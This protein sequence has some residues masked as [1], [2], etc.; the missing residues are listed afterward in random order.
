M[1]KKLILFFICT[2][3]FFSFHS[4][5]AEVIIN[6][7]QIAGS[8]ANDEFIELYNSGDS[9]ANLT[10]FYIKKKTS[11][12]SESSFVVPSRFEGV[13][14][15]SG[16]YLL[17]AR[18]N[19]Y[20][21]TVS[22]DIFWPSSYSLANNN[23]LT[24]FRGNET[25]KNEVSWQTIEEN[26]SFQ[27]TTT[28]WIIAVA[29]PKAQNPNSSSSA[30][31]GTGTL[32]SNN[33]DNDD[34]HSTQ[35][36]NSTE[37]KNKII[38][39][40]KIKTKIIT[41]NNVFTGT[42]SSFQAA[43]FGYSKEKLNYGKYFWNFGDGDSKEIQTNSTEKL[44]HTYLYPGDYVVTLEYYM[45]FY[46]DVPDASDKM[47]IK[48]TKAN[49]LISAVG[50]SQ[51]FFVELS[52]NTDYDADI[53]N[54]SL[55]SSA[56]NFTFPKNTVISSKKKMTISSV[57]T[58]FS[59]F[60]KDTLKL[61]TPQGRIVFDY[62]ISLIP[63]VPIEK[64]PVQSKQSKISPAVQPLE[65]QLEENTATLTDTQIPVE[66][67]GASIVSSGIVKD[68][69]ISFPS[70]IALIFIGASGGAVYFL[71]KKKIISSAGDDF[72]ILDE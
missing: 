49:F 1:S 39:E 32:I 30:P 58:H 2:I 33:S 71:R 42:A 51:D 12:G 61:I 52:N 55:S 11:S 47:T 9:V 38:E 53:G 29:T 8:T 14:I 46:G 67:L 13:T 21:G 7:V 28:G 34:N 19:E 16:G 24:L 59:V 3:L 6:E 65:K 5:Y 23:S 27:K 57:L 66:N 37:T 20:M 48:V 40:P 45:N 43:T 35:N 4:A 69:L 36:T 63:A 54:W 15:S 10:D 56:K 18:E 44:S 64:I 41:K 62:G 68:S 22:P 70:I 50:D 17:L 60:D 26:K 25:D 72:K 31:V